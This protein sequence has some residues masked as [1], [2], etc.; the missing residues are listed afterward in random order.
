VKYRRGVHRTQF[1]GSTYA[2][3]NCTPTSGANG[4]RESSDGKYDHSGGYIRALVKRSE[5]T[6]PNS[7]GWSLADLD[8]AMK[9]ANIPFTV[10]SGAGWAAVRAYR[11]SGHGI[12][13]Q[14]DSDQFTTG[15]SAKFDGDH[16]VYVHPETSSREG[17][18][19]WLLGDPIC[20]DWRWEKESVLRHYAEKF[21]PSIRFGT[22]D[23]P[24]RQIDTGVEVPPMAQ[25]THTDEVPKLIDIPLGAIIYDLDG[26]TQLGK[27]TVAYKARLSPYAVA[28]GGRAIYGGSFD[29]GPRTTRIVKAFSNVVPVPDPTPYSAADINAATTKGVQQEKSRLR[30]LLGL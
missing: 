12:A 2:G 4:A 5:E 23:T 15:C 25:A 17:V 19:Y 1:D 13:L 16:C 9:R 14:G 11:E 20:G 18:V 30:T 29:P 22:F 10:R 8:L 7:P 3:S 24:V 6:D 27:T 21:S 26:T 28:G